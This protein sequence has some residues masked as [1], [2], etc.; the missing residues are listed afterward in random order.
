[1]HLGIVDMLYYKRYWDE[2]RG[3]DFDSWGESHWWLEVC[4]DG[5]VSKCFHIYQNDI[6]LLYTKAHDEDEFGMLPEGAIEFDEFKEFKITKSLFE[7]KLSEIEPI[8]G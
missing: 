4:P 1:M 6:V 7:S 8:N 2:S 5:S 3:D